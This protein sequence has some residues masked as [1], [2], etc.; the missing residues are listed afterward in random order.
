MI[1]VCYRYRI[2]LNIINII[3]DNVSFNSHSIYIFYV[4]LTNRRFSAIVF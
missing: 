3:R 2:K 4:T 1:A